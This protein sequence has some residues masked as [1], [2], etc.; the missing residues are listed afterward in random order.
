M[1]RCRDCKFWKVTKDSEKEAT[2][3]GECCSKK[4]RRGYHEKDILADEILV[5]D[6][7]G[8]AFVTGPEFGCVHWEYS[9]KVTQ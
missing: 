6:D 3:L 4:W 2:G 1:L 7:E 5:E 9:G 8:W